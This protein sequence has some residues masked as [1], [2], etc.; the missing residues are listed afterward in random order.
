MHIPN[1]LQSRLTAI[2]AGL[3]I[4]VLP[5]TPG[6]FWTTL[7]VTELCEIREDMLLECNPHIN[8]TKFTEFLENE[9]AVMEDIIDLE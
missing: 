7:A 6:P 8:I 1:F 4:S 2:A 5:D 3:F 9:L